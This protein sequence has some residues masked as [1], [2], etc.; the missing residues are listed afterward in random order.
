MIHRFDLCGRVGASCQ[1]PLSA[2]LSVITVQ[3]VSLD[4]E[5]CHCWTSTLAR[6][7]TPGPAFPAAES[8][9]FSQASRGCVAWRAFIQLSPSL[10]LP[11]QASPFDRMNLRVRG[12]KPGTRVLE[13][14][15]RSIQTVPSTAGAG[16]GQGLQGYECQES[17]MV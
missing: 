1:H 17:R 6:R 2:T 14:G 4:T 8:V 10:P 9:L 7:T 5:E 11:S 13:T 16:P 12:R 3:L 15:E